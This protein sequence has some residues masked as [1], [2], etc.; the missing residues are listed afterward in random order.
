MNNLKKAAVHGSFIKFLLK[1]YECIYILMINK[2]K[3]QPFKSKFI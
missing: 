1:L 3:K 2:H